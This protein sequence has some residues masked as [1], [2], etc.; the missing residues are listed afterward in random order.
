MWHRSKVAAW[1]VRPQCL[2][3]GLPVT[4]QDSHPPLGHGHQPRAPNPRA[5]L[6][7][8]QSLLLREGLQVGSGCKPLTRVLEPSGTLSVTCH[9]QI[10]SLN[11]SCNKH[12]LSILFGVPQTLSTLPWGSFHCPVGSFIFLV[13]DQVAIWT[14]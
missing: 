13:L 6:T 5:R 9:V 3:G 1:I 4:S 2:R 10:C 8:S 7:V 12:V 11:L 14:P